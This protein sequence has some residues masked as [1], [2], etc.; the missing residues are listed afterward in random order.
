[1]PVLDTVFWMRVNA[2][3]NLKPLFWLPFKIFA[4][5]IL[6]HYIF[7]LGISIPCQT[8]IDSGFYIGHY[9]G[10]IVSSKAKIGKNCNISQNVTIGRSCRGFRKGTPTIGNNVYIAPGA[11]IFGHIRIGDNVAIGANCVV[12]KD[13]PA[14]SVVVGVPGKIISQKGSCGYIDR[15]DYESY[16]R[17]KI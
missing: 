1:V 13:I 14:N 5:L 2:Y 15:T 12:T 3:I 6:H 16:L 9:G 4:K 7:K 11:K 10:I 17:R 8:Q